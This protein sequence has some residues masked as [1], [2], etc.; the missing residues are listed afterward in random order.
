MNRNLRRQAYS[1]RPARAEPPAYTNGRAWIEASRRDNPDEF[2]NKETEWRLHLEA[3]GQI[4]VRKEQ[5]LGAGEPR[6]F[7]EDPNL[8]AEPPH[9]NDG[10]YV[11]AREEAMAQSENSGKSKSWLGRVFKR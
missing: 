8:V 10:V 4:P 2:S 7:T 6:P 5:S 11:R 9:T 3:I 1:E